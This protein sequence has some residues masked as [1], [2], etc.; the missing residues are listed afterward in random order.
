MRSP[1]AI[2]FNWVMVIGFSIGPLKLAFVEVMVTL[3]PES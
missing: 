2:P 1:F 3:A